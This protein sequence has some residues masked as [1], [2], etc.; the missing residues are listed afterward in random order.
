MTPRPVKPHARPRAAPL[1]A[2]ALSELAVLVRFGELVVALAAQHVSRIVMAD[3]A[4][5]VPGAP[6]SVRIG[7]AVLPAWELGD[8]LALSEAPAAWVVLAAGDEPGAPRFAL[9]TGPCI[10]VSS[11]DAVS[12][13][14]PGVVSVP[15]AAVIGVFVTDPT[16]RERGLG[17]LGVRIDPVRLIGAA[18]IAAAARRGER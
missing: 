11:H 16:L 3:E 1:T 12:P 6:S 2:R 8:L 14:P 13:L 17:P 9:G 18:A 10:A 5:E 15:P 4:E 7:D